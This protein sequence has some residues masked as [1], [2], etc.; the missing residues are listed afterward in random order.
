MALNLEPDNVGVV[1]FGNDKL[2]REGDVVKRTGAIVDVPVGDSILG[3]VVDALGNPIDGKGPI[4]G[5]KRLMNYNLVFNI[6][7]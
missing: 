2:I 5:G 7:L 3:R 6:F 1:V 4:T